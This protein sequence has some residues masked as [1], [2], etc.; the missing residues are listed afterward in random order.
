VGNPK[1]LHVYR[2]K[3]ACLRFQGN[4]GASGCRSAACAGGKIARLPSLGT[5]TERAVARCAKSGDRMNEKNSKRSQD[6]QLS[7][8][9]KNLERIA[10][11]M[12]TTCDG[13]RFRSR[14][15]RGIARPEENA[16]VFITERSTRK[17]EEIEANPMLIFASQ[18]CRRIHSSRCPA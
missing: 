6:E 9:W 16:I 11:C 10:T 12:M 14:P 8:I 1:R 17:P 13:G 2:T 4:A 5:K 7:F 15:M 18:I 3:F